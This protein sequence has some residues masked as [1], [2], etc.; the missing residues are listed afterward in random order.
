MP[1][2][3]KTP[4]A[5]TEGKDK[6]DSNNSITDSSENVKGFS[7]KYINQS[8]KSDCVFA[9]DKSNKCAALR[10]RECENCKFYKTE[11]EYDE[12]RKRAEYRLFGKR[13]VPYKKYVGDV[14]IMTVKKIRRIYYY[15]HGQ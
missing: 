4:S 13:P 7:E 5:L 8:S 6:N 1:A 11:K 14:L 12:S 9:D 10:V 2:H 15:G 3:K